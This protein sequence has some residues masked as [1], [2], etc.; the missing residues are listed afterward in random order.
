M[1]DMTKYLLPL[2]YVAT[3]ATVPGSVFMR[4]N[5]VGVIREA[6]SGLKHMF[7]HG[8]AHLVSLPEKL[9]AATTRQ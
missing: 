8:V 9:R 2:C 5:G 1:K 3:I 7:K 4:L 6:S